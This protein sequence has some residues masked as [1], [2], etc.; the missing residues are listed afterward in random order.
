M[1]N[2]VHILLVLLFSSSFI[3]A[4][5]NEE[6]KPIKTS[7]NG[8]EATQA[9]EGNVTFS[10]GS[11]A[12]IRITDEGDFG[13][14]ELSNGIPAVK[15]NKL[16]NNNGRLY[17]E[18]TELGLG[19][20]SS[21]LNDLQD[22]KFDG[23]SLFIGE[24]SGI[25]DDGGNSD[26]IN[27]YNTS[28][29]ARSLRL[30]VVGSYN[31]AVGNSAL[32]I[33][34]IG[35]RNVSIGYQTLFTNNS[36]SDNTVLGT[37]A[38][39]YNSGGNKN[40]VNGSESM[41]S[42]LQGSQNSAFGYQAMYKNFLGN[43]NIGIGAYSN[44]FNKDGN[45]NTII[46]FEAGKGTSDHT[47]SGNVFLGYQAGFSEVGSNKL[48][49]ENS[50]SST[51]LI[52]GDFASDSIQLNGNLGITGN[53]NVDGNIKV[54]GNLN[55]NGH[56]TFLNNK[57]I[58]Q[59]IDDL[60]DSKT[61]STSLFLGKNAGNSENFSNSNIGIGNNSSLNNVSGMYNVTIGNATN[62]KN[63]T[64]SRNTIIG[65]QA[66]RGVN[67]NSKSGNVFIGY[68]AGFYE[69]NNNKLYI[70]NDSSNTPLIGGDFST[71]QVNIN[72][73]LEVTNKVVMPRLMLTEGA[74]EGYTL[75]S[76][77]N[78]NTTWQ[79]TTIPKIGFFAHLG[80]NFNENLLSS[81]ASQINGFI[82]DMDEGSV[83]NE[84]TG[85]FTAPTEGFYHFD[86][87]ITWIYVNS[88]FDTEIKIKKNGST[89]TGSSYKTPVIKNYE[90]SVSFSINV[91]LSA[92]D[93]ITLWVDAYLQIASPGSNGVISG[94]ENEYSSN[95]S[96][97]KVF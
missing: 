77:A 6:K 24:E 42:N 69:T 75:T 66:G 38:M 34:S 11:N 61:N 23:E 86:I 3:I 62:M 39:Y 15:I 91:F 13:A 22:A 90:N 2:T 84:S 89:F 58:P 97:Y 81:N 10:D 7:V 37:N 9:V 56:I 20:G 32:F 44:Y 50:N 52:Y 73:K 85:E 26:G 57:T 54:D 83:F 43:S 96:G 31:V 40:S 45:N 95:F 64:G 33:N 36:G 67:A 87:N 14:I 4:Q 17:F 92:N 41:Y 19:S 63:I 80:S 29:G 72:G 48:Y 28:V 18:D 78:G 5:Q 21:Q 25:V 65:Y 49:I 55:V 70:N 47:K 93:I 53:H 76:D 59:A 82:V 30:N 68:K 46:G 16:Y 79:N 51:P 27:N 8:T 60:A 94:G 88:D 74:T 35:H 1:K 12:L 71:K